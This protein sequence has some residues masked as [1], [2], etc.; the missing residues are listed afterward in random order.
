ML[1][2]G[3]SDDGLLLML[4]RLNLF[5]FIYDVSSLIVAC[6]YCCLLV[7][8]IASL[9]VLIHTQKKLYKQQN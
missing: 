1:Y 7:D 4:M 8:A 5:V 2:I 3:L 9:Y 6:I